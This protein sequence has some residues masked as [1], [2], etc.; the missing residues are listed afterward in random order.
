M[1]RIIIVGGGAGGLELATRLGDRYGARGN[2]PAQALVTLVDRYPTHIWK[3]LLHEVAA[4]SMDPFTQELEYA[5]QARWHGFEFQ[6]GELVG[7]DRATKRITLSPVNDSD[8]AELLPQRTLDYDTLVIA[9]G[10][11]THF[12]GVQGAQENAI[13][14]DTVAEAERFRK[15]L[16]AA[17][18]RAEHQNPAP[19]EVSGNPPAPAEPRIQ[20]AIVGGGATGVELS[21]ELRNTAQVLSAYGLHKLDPRHDVGIVLIESGP[22]IL[23]ALQERVSTATAEL[24]EKLGVRL[25]LSERVT[26][27]APGVVR[28]ASGKSVRAD[29][30]VWA[31]G[32]KAPAVLARLDGLQVNKLGQLD[33]RRTLQAANDDNVFALGDC[34]ACAWPGNERNVPP[35]AQAAHQ[36]ASFLLKAIG[37]KL[38]G[39]PLPEFTYRDFG[40]LVSLGHFSAV[41]NLMGG[42]IGGNMLIEGLFARFM[43]MSL[44]R[45]HIAALHG[46]PRMMLDTVA[47]WLRRTTLPR[48]KLH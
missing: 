8:G 3:P 1:H 25:M 18:M 9:I 20:V 13:A 7:L 28:T 32:I 40:S 4:G 42:L 23:P 22:R 27:V 15:R 37:C 17:C 5:A 21:A 34:A 43:Y 44:Y 31:A 45:L 14:L 16:I 24:L 46:Y 29:L 30:T 38:E 41:G 11:T 47:H 33:V 12:F 48:V 35:R 6:Q 2:R 19:V 10:S 39:R 26:E 36:Q